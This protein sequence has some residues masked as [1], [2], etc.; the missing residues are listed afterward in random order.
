MSYT[1]VQTSPSN[2]NVTKDFESFCLCYHFNVEPGKTF[3]LQ[4]G[5]FAVYISQKSGP[6]FV[7]SLYDDSQL[8]KQ[9][10]ERKLEISNTAKHKILI[11]YP[12]LV[13]SR[14]SQF[15]NEISQL[16]LFEFTDLNE[17]NKRDSIDT[18]GWTPQ[19][20][21]PEKNDDG[22]YFLKQTLSFAAVKERYVYWLASQTNSNGA[23]RFVAALPFVSTSLIGTIVGLH[24]QPFPKIEISVDEK[25]WSYP[26]LGKDDV[27]G[28]LKGFI[29][30]ADGAFKAISL[31]AEIDTLCELS[32]QEKNH[33]EIIS[34][35]SQ[36]VH[37]YPTK[38]SRTL[39]TVSD[40]QN[41]SIILSDPKLPIEI[42]YMEGIN[43]DNSVPLIVK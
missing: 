21:S 28:A 15:S 34:Y 11:N 41:N 27:E 31:S 7:Q 5:F 43:K 3:Q 32:G 23:E 16:H 17:Q 19:F 2:I 30:V 8:G 37:S 9:D 40:T 25:L 6:P 22:R 20:K 38:L 36:V 12:R 39:S 33:D 18:K 14:F 1:L 4:N 35:L 26:K 42:L 13:N 29:M 10:L 24:S